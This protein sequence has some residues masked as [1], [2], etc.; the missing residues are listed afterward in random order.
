MIEAGMTVQIDAAGN[1]IGHYAGMQLGAAALA[2]G[3]HIDTVPVGGRYDGCLG[4]LAGLEIVRTLNE[5]EV[6]LNHP[7]EVIVFTDEERSV[8]GSKTM[9]GG[10]QRI[11]RTLLPLGWHPD[12]ALFRKSGRKLGSNCSGETRSR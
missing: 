10:N 11:T 3:S 4:V 1:I 9:A 7:I 12:P 8:I 2:T 5:N 6:H